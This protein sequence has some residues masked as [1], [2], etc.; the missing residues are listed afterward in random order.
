MGC[1]IPSTVAT[2]RSR[3]RSGISSGIRVPAV[4]SANKSGRMWR[5][6]ATKLKLTAKRVSGVEVLC[7]VLWCGVV[8]CG[9]V[10][11]G[12]IFKKQLVPFLS[13]IPPAR[14]NDERYSLCTCQFLFQFIASLDFLPRHDHVVGFGVMMKLLCRLTYRLGYICM[15]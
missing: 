13:S 6:V 7:C 2:L 3:Y 1:P 11:C 8:F 4:T 15:E 10:W 5:I 12:G 14:Y 9:V